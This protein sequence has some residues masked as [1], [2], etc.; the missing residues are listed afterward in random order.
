[1]KPQKMLFLLLAFVCTYAQAQNEYVKNASSRFYQR[2]F[3]RLMNE[4]YRP[5]AVTSKIQQVIDYEPG[6]SPQLGYWATFEK[7]LNT[8]PWV[9]RH[10]LTSAQYQNEFNTWVG[11]GYMPTDINVAVLNNV[12]S[13]SVIFDKV[14]NAPAWQARH[15]MSTATFKKT[16]STMSQQGFRRTLTTYAYRG[17]EY[18]YAALWSK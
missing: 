3:A 17:G 5:I 10:G 13:Y 18:V 2:E 6:E 11:Q 14:P 12:T 8:N 9:A 7:R 1:M 15:E 4:G 16:D